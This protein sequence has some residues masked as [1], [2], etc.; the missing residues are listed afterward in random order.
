M[1]EASPRERIGTEAL[2]LLEELCAI[3]SP[4]GDRRGLTQM[5]ERLARAF[6]EVGLPSRI[7]PSGADALPLLLAGS[8]DCAGALLVAGHLDTVLPAIRPRREADRLVGTG[9]I[10][11]K[12]GLAAFWGA[13]AL[14]RAEGTVTGAWPADWGLVATPDEEVGGAVTRRTLA[15]FGGTARALWVL[16]PGARRDDEGETLVVGR[17]GVV[18]FHLEIDGRAAHAG[19]DFPS[20]RSALA[21]AAEWVTRA[22]ALTA[23]GRGPTVNP[24]RLVAGEAAAVDAPAALASLLGTPRQVNVV[25]DRARID[26]EARFFSESD[27]E[28]VTA[29]LARL[30]DEIGRSREV[31]CAIDIG[32]PIPPLELTAL[33]LAA[34]ERAVAL[35]A[36]RGWNLELE[37]DRGGISFPN[38][39]PAGVALPV[40]DGLGPVGGGMHTRD[41][42]LDLASFSRRVELL[43][44]LLAD[45]LGP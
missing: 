7:E 10:D 9:A 40:L 11:M 39:L 42:F 31:R 30:A 6:D 16:E 20:G 32:E 18:H 14:L 38:F 1:N 15:R 37:D 27:G 33:R 5:A 21:A 29:E 22:T 17:R 34:A 12:G 44:D 4:S 8:P 26:G 23:P 3:S 45:E 43:A 25:P 2:A 41:E 28:E 35:A 19:V 24:A 36:A 13:L